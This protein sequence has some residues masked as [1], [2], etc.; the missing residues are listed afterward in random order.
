VV[1][2]EFGEVGIDD[3]LIVGGSN[4]TVLLGNGCL[5]CRIRSDLE[6]TLRTLFTDR[7]RGAIPG[8]ARV[9]LE[10]SGLDDPAPFL[11]TL[12]SDR[13]LGREYH[14][15]SILTLL[16]LATGEAALAESPEARRQVAIADR[17]LLTKADL[18]P[19]GAAE[20]L[21]PALRALN[22][23]APIEATAPGAIPRPEWLEESDLPLPSLLTADALTRHTAGL[24]TFT[25]TFGQ[26]WSWPAL[27]ATLDLLLRLCGES[28][29]RAKGL[30]AL[31]GC[32]GPVA[33]HA[34]RHI[35]HR[36]VELEAWPKGD[37]T[38]R[39]VFITRNLPRE[40]VEALLRA[41]HHLAPPTENTP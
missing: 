11:Q 5:C 29:L 34:V 9:I 3:A 13:A 23:H 41:A 1:V 40:A 25:I 16:D 26:P 21:A 17:I 39:L 37:S 8:F 10:T 2:N 36:P 4:D 32:T 14:L 31:E 35:L 15:Q 33:I 12:L 6:T 19:A 20:R 22:P 30:V 24:A 28:I 38:S 27:E 18:A 7:M